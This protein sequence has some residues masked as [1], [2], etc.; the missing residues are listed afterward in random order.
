IEVDGGVALALG[1][2]GE[3]ADSWVRCELRLGDAELAGGDDERAL[4]GIALHAPAA[5]AGDER[6]IVGERRRPQ[7]PRHGLPRARASG[8]GLA[9]GLELA[10]GDVAA[11]R[12]LDE[13]VA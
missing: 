9:C 11:A 7:R 3:L 1:G 6:R 2:E 8:N 5:V 4:G 12:H 10:L 13:A